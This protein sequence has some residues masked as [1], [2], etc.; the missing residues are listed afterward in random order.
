MW[1]EVSREAVRAELGSVCPY[2]ERW[3]ICS[4]AENN[5]ADGC[6]LFELAVVEECTD[7]EECYA[8]KLG[9]CEGW[10]R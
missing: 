6:E 2:C 3:E 7:C 8:L 1:S 9:V 4:E 5:Y 10:R